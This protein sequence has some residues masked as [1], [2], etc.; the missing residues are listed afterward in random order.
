MVFRELNAVEMYVEIANITPPVWRRLILPL[1]TNLKHLHR[2]LQAV[3]G[4]KD[5]HLHE[6][7]IGGLRYGDVERAEFDDMP[8]TFAEA[9]VMLNDF[10]RE[11]GT[12]FQYIYDFGDSWV[13]ILTVLKVLSLTPAPRTATCIAGGRCCPPE[14][15]G[16]EFGYA[17]FLRLLLRPDKEEIDEQQRL[18]RWSGGNFDPEWFD[19]AKT[20]KA[21]RG[22]LRK[23]ASK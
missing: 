14:D 22:A 6:Y 13:H 16:G 4:W 8:R 20:D 15:V 1:S 2:I 17:K 9:K 23:T 19:L 3:M 18:K 7:R 12:E 11:A 10:A 5:C 21:V